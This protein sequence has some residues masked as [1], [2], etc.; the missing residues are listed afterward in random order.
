[1]ALDESDFSKIAEI[2]NQTLDARQSKGNNGGGNGGGNN[3]GNDGDDIAKIKADA[4]AKAKAESALKSAMGFN[5]TR[6]TFMTDNKQYLPATIETVVKALSGRQYKSEQE[7]ADN[8]R[9]IILDEVF[10]SQAN[11]DLMPE[12]AKAKIAKYK[13]M[14]D[15]DRVNNAG[16]YF[17]LVDTFLTLKKGIAQK[18]FNKNG[19]GG[20]SDAYAQKFADLGKAFTNKGA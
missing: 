20:G 19:T 7:E 14:A 4:E 6:A 12:S 1:M 9:K 5:L 18:E 2:V 17:E 13:S 15:S 10:E 3:N 8:Y 16:D 11:I